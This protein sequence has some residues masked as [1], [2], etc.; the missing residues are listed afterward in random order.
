MSQ[1]KNM[2]VGDTVEHV[3]VFKKGRVDGF[4]RR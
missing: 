1:T 3:G 2:M 4:A